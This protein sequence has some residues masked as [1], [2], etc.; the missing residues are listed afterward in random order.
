MVFGNF[1]LRSLRPIRHSFTCHVVFVIYQLSTHYRAERLRHFAAARSVSLPLP[2]RPCQSR[3]H[4]YVTHV[5]RLPMS[6]LMPHRLDVRITSYTREARSPLCRPLS[7]NF[8]ITRRLPHDV[9]SCVNIIDTPPPPLTPDILIEFHASI[10]LN[11]GGG[12]FHRC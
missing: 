1:R 6:L 3:C 4:D 8:L 7:P 10:I 2:P 11:G 9:L 5:T 12:E